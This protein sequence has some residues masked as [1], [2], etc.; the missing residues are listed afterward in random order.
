MDLIN[1]IFDNVT[2]LMF[3]SIIL[4][5]LITYISIPTIVSVAKTKHLVDEPSGRTSH[6]G[7]IPT[8]GGIAIFAG[9]LISLLIFIDLRLF[10]SIQYITPGLLILFFIGLKDDILSI[11]W[12]KKLLGQIIAALIVILLGDIR[13]T[14]LHGFFGVYE[15][16]YLL[17]V[18]LSLF[19]FI[20]IINCFNLIDGIDGLSAGMGIIASIVLGV[21]FFIINNNQY[22]I[23]SFGITGSLL[24]YFYFNVFSKKNKI[25][26]GDT[27]ALIIGFLIAVLIIEF[28]EYNIGLNSIYAI[29]SAPAV[30]IGILFVPLFDTL[31]VFIIRISRKKSPFHPDMEHLHHKLIKI[32]N[33]HFKATMILL[34][35]NILF[36]IIVY[37]LQGIGILKLTSIILILGLLLSLIPVFLAR[38][39]K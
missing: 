23:L 8:L 28:N 9:I 12:K 7:S 38:K 29:K 18:L 34:G 2:F 26:M 27:G 25:F 6:N 31:R 16:G 36:I 21:W 24:A 4:S 32:G 10:S 39:K 3:S 20:V 14:N 19:I 30:S 11:S 1:T 5:F 15:I 13:I 35:I 22:F 33:S 37:F 17:S